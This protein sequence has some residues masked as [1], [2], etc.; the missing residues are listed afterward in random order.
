MEPYLLWGSEVLAAQDGFS[1]LQQG[2]QGLRHAP[3]LSVSAAGPVQ[4]VPK[5]L[6]Q[7]IVRHYVAYDEQG[8]ARVA[9]SRLVSLSARRQE[10]VA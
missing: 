5:P 8:Q 1:L 3:P 10:G 2:A 4:R 9:V 6:T 7:A